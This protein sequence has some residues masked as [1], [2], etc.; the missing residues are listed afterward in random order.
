MK[1]KKGWQNK[2]LQRYVYRLDRRINK[3]ILVFHR[4]CPLRAAPI[5][6][7]F[8]GKNASFAFLA[9]YAD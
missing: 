5:Y 9:G 4:G 7:K 6:W 2:E 8:N 1:N 3:T